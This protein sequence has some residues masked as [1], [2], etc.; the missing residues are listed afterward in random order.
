MRWPWQRAKPAEVARLEQDLALIVTKHEWPPRCSFCQGHDVYAI[1]TAF[2]RRP[3]SGQVFVYR[4]SPFAWLCVPCK[5]I[6]RS[7]DLSVDTV[8]VD[9]A[10]EILTRLASEAKASHERKSSP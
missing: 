5:A 4:T 8:H 7:C 1:A 2:E 9:D 6:G 3:P 10:D